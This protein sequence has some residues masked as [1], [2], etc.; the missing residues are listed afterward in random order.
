MSSTE[1]LPVRLVTRVQG[2][3]LQAT[4]CLFL[5]DMESWHQHNRLAWSLAGR[6]QW[7]GP[8]SFHPNHHLPVPP[9]SF[10]LVPELSSFG[11][12]ED[13]SRLIP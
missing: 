8:T 10:S 12:I 1:I 11:L 7:Y 4:E 9:P 5:M 6:F 2:I 3:P 13:P